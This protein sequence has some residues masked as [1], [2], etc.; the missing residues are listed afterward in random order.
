MRLSRFVS[1]TAPASMLALILLVLGAGP[2]LAAADFN[3]PVTVPNGI[4]VPA[5]GTTLTFGGSIQARVHVVSSA[6]GN[7]HVQVH[8]TADGLTATDTAGHA[9]TFH[10]V[11][12]AELNLR[13][14][15]AG[16]ATLT[17]NITAAGP[18]PLGG[19]H[20]HIVAHITVNDNNEITVAFVKAFVD[21]K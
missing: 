16:E 1:R 11:A 12:N 13:P 17:G 7:V 3:G 19:S 5:C 10:G 9:Y 20:A 2:A 15:V 18:S 14:N 21:C 6:S 4:S 8:A